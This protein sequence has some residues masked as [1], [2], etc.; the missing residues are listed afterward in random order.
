MSGAGRGELLITWI[1][2]IG[3]ETRKQGGGDVGVGVLMLE[4]KPHSLHVTLSLT[5]LQR[6]CL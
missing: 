2:V 1:D 6:L 3:R 4:E 5:R